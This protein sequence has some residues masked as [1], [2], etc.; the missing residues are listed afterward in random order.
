[1]ARGLLTYAMIILTSGLAIILSHVAIGVGADST[2]WP[3]FSVIVVY[4]WLL[5]RPD[6]LSVPLVFVIGLF[7]DLVLGSIVGAGLIALLIATFAFEGLIKPLRTMPL[8]RRWLGFAAFA[9]VVFGLE[10]CLTAV[11]LLSAPPHQIAM[12]QCGMTFLVYPAV[13]ITLRSVLRIGR[14]PRR[15]F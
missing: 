10:W 9:A 6:Y 8:V 5:H 2:P 13:S 3:R 14:T 12:V 4:F 15:A 7:Q 11:A 1:M